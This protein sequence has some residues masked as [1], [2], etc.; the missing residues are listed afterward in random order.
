MASPNN[1]HLTADQHRMLDIYTAQ[2]RQ[3]SDQINQLYRYLDDIRSN[4]NMVMFSNTNSNSNSN[5][6]RN[7]NTRPTRENDP[8]I[9]YDYNN[10]INPNIYLERLASYQNFGH[11]ITNQNRNQNTNRNQNRNANVNSNS[12]TYGTSD[13]TADISGLLSSFLN[14]NVIVRPTNQQIEN[15]TTLVSYSDIIHPNSDTCPISLER[16][17]PT[18]QVRQINYC[19]HIFL[20]NEFNEWF[21]SN[22]RCPVCRYDIRN[23]R[24]SSIITSPVSGPTGPSSPSSEEIR[25]FGPSGA[26]GYTSEATTTTGATGTTTTGVTTG[27]TTGATAGA[28][29]RTI[30]NENISN[31]NIVRNPQTNIVDEISF[32]I[33][34]NTITNDIVSTLTNRLFETLFVP[35]AARNNTNDH[36]VYD[37]SNNVLMYESIS[38]PNDNNTRPHR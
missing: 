9:F 34:G 35:S 10:P 2:Y 24:G 27:V 5:Y 26:C 6:N 1:T 30:N 29:A 3:T 31:V 22:V 19:G 7:R 20:S 38:R 14:S 21:H 32:D 33:S 16:F 18:D 12:N 8:P 15:A 25:E 13:I 28:S 36:F 17:N 11:R 23:N 37:P 4:I